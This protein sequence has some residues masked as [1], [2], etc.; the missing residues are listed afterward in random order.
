MSL[1]KF[2]VA[3]LKQDF[4]QYAEERL[5]GGQVAETW[6]DVFFNKLDENGICDYSQ[7]KLLDYGCGDGRYFP[8]LVQKGFSPDNIYGIE[9]SQKRIERC[10]QLGWQNASYV[11]LKAPLDYEDNF[12][13]VVNLIDVIEHIP[14]EEI[15][16][17]LGEIT[18]ILKPEGFLILTTPNYPVKRICDLMTAFLRNKWKRLKDDPTHVCKYNRN[19]LERTL[20]PYFSSI[21][22]FVY[23]EGYLYR[24]IKNEKLVHKFLVTASMA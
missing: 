17:Y 9:A 1:E 16:F 2:R 18:R 10:K 4:E 3:K 22:F 6:E 20:S 8:Y 15:D 13:D 14:S 11:K 24:R 7:V 19:K 5:Q 12:F 23:K 21:N